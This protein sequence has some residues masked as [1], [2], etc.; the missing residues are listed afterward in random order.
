MFLALSVCYISYGLGLHSSCYIVGI[1]QLF[2]TEQWNRESS[3]ANAHLAQWWVARDSK[4]DVVSINPN[5]VLL[6]WY[7]IFLKACVTKYMYIEFIFWKS[8]A[9]VDHIYSAGKWAVLIFYYIYL[10]RYVRAKQKSEMIEYIRKV[11]TRM[12]IY[13]IIF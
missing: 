13:M 2:F 5:S 7:N 10:G 6:N 1:F 11:H 3:T 4:V 12:Y 9:V 8:T